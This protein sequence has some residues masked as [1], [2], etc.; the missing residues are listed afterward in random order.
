MFSYFVTNRCEADTST[1]SF[2]EIAVRRFEY[3]YE[4]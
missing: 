4:A 3:L 2:S 1:I